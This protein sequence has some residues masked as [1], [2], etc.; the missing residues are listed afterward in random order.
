MQ[1]KANG[2][3]LLCVQVSRGAYIDFPIRR[4]RTPSSFVP[5]GFVHPP[6]YCMWQRELSSTNI[7][8]PL[9]WQR[10]FGSSDLA[11]TLESTPS[12]PSGLNFGITLL[13]CTTPW[14]K[15]AFEFKDGEFG[16][17]Q[18]CRKESR[19]RFHDTDRPSVV[20]HEQYLEV[21][22][23]VSVRCCSQTHHS[24]RQQYFVNR[25]PHWRCSH[26][27]MAGE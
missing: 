7:T 20:T 2:R 14:R 9:R 6:K 22:V 24:H 26:V 13:L 4:F 12:P 11:I 23:E 17:G 1:V 27:R 16:I 15:N 10:V 5:F 21:S 18:Q 19:G 8:K 3:C 25:I